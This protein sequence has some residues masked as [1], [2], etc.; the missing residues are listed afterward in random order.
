MCA[1]M[2]SVFAP[3]LSINP[4][5]TVHE[6]ADRVEHLIWQSAQS[7]LWLWNRLITARGLAL[8]IYI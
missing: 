1:P 4:F 5:Y 8:W 7:P 2:P 6:P 3:I